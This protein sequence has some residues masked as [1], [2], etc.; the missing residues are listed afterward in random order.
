[1]YRPTHE[2]LKRAT[3]DEETG[4]DDGGNDTIHLLIISLAPRHMYHGHDS[5]TTSPLNGLQTIAL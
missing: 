3:A 2:A 1:M 5:R 4:A